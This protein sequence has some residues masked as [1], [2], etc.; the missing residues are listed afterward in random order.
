[1]LEEVS[2]GKYPRLR[3]ILRLAW[4]S[5][6]ENFGYRQLTVWWRL[7]GI[8]QHL[9]RRNLTWGTMTRQ[10]FA[11]TKPAVFGVTPAGGE[12]IVVLSPED[13]SKFNATDS[14]K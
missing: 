13:S 10:G 6:A 12:A 7:K 2:Y 1:M 3:D 5:V 8:W 9:T 11:D 14:K 4:Y